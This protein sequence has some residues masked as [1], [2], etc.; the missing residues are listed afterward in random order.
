MHDGNTRN[1]I[2]TVDDDTFPPAATIST[3]PGVP[4][5]NRDETQRN[6]RLTSSHPLLPGPRAGTELLGPAWTTSPHTGTGPHYE[7]RA[8]T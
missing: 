7:T 2:V 3:L 1:N 4:L 5:E 6:V 8:W